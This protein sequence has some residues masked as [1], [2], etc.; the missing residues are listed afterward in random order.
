MAQSNG[1]RSKRD[2][3]ARVFVIPL[4]WIAALLVGYWLL[5][6]WNTLPMM[7]GGALAEIS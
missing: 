5:A 2:P 3:G 4:L 1:D 7:I 6:D